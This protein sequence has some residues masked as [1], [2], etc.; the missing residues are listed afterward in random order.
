M[1]DFEDQDNDY[2]ERRRARPEPPR[3]AGGGLHDPRAD[4]RP[5]SDGETQ[6]LHPDEYAPRRPARD[7][8]PED[9][10]WEDENADTE[11]DQTP[12]PRR[13]GRTDMR[14]DT[15]MQ[16][17]L[18]VA[19]GEDADVG[20]DDQDDFDDRMPS[21]RYARPSMAYA[22]AYQ[23]GSGCGAALLYVTLGAIAVFVLLLLVG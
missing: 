6:K 3:P 22:P 14:R 5:A 8:Y 18:R 20:Y 4:P 19:R 15:L 13:S 7:P 17:R 21:R 9:E 11:L 23:R 10:L 16:R 1:T 12:A 2:R